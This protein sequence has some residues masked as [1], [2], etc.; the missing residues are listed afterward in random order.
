MATDR[1]H[2]PTEGRHP[3]S[4]DLD[5]MSTPE[6]IDLMH[7][8]DVQ[9]ARAVHAQKAQIEKAVELVVRSFR[10]GGRLFYV[11]AGTSG[12]L[13]VL[14][15]SECAPTF[16]A[17]PEMVQGVIAG[18]PDALW[19]SVEQ[20]EDMPEAAEE[21]MAER[22][23]GDADAVMGIATGATTP[24]PQAA[25]REAKRRGAATI[26]LTC[27]PGFAFCREVDVA[28]ELDTGPEIVTGSTRLKGGTATK[29]VLNMLSTISMVRLGK[30]YGNLMVDLRVVN[31]K[32]VDRAE[33]ILMTACAI[34][35]AEAGALLA[36]CRGQVKVGIVMQRCA[37]DYDEARR[38]IADQDGQLRPIVGDPPDGGSGA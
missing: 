37:L 19:R 34:D 32:L 3:A 7:E 10:A 2:L 5:V 23:V 17:P 9:A 14:D 35:R 8:Q 27:C 6:I 33:R 11:G 29:M 13:G 38:R 22:N 12:R 16:H 28:I 30:T 31:S 25:V 24:F 18:W 21:A 15:A 36:S 20:V 4:Q 1:G 26:F